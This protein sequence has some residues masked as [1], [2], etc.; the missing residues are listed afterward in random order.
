V[1]LFPTLYEKTLSRVFDARDYGLCEL[2]DLLGQ[3]AEASVV[4][5]AA[6][7]GEELIALPKREQT[8]E[9]MERTKQFAVEV[10][11]VFKVFEVLLSRNIL[12]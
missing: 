12:R 3:V 10:R 2:S 5:M 8:F 7:D 1:S 6:A 4:V 11:K 9:E